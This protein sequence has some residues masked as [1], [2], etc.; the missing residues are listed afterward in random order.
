MFALILSMSSFWNKITFDTIKQKI[1][2]LLFISECR[3]SNI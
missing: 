1:K 2:A 3:V